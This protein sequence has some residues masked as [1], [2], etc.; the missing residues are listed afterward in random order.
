MRIVIN[1]PD[2]H[3]D[4]VADAIGRP[5]LEVVAEIEDA[6]RDYFIQQLKASVRMSRLREL[7]KNVADVDLS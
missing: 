5:E 6:A 4:L 1:V 3:K 7:R 2:R